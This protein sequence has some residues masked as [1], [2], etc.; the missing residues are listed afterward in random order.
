MDVLSHLGVANSRVSLRE[1]LNEEALIY[2]DMQLYS[3]V[4]FVC[5]HWLA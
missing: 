1:E 5:R 2:S 4:N 3:L